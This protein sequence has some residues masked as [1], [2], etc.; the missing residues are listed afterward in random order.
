MAAGGTRR[1]ERKGEP[2]MTNLRAICIL[3]FCHLCA[4][5][6][7]TPP[8]PPLPAA[9]TTGT[10]PSET[11]LGVRAPEVVTT[12]AKTRTEPALR[13]L[14]P[15][16]EQSKVFEAVYQK[17]ETKARRDLKILAGQHFCHSANVN[18]IFETLLKAF[19]SWAGQEIEYARW[20]TLHFAGIVEENSEF[21]RQA[22]LSQ[23]SAATPLSL[24][25]VASAKA[26]SE[27][28]AL[29]AGTKT[30]EAGLLADQ[31]EY[32]AMQRQLSGTGVASLLTILNEAIKSAAEAKKAAESLKKGQLNS[33]WTERLAAFDH[34]REAASDAFAYFNDVAKTFADRKNTILEERANFPARCAQ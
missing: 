8:T 27:T 24:P 29:E 17:A 25:A 19:D 10:F 18:S 12:A 30:A 1:I 2:P 31:E 5:Q 34:E 4:A 16:R 11:P 13:E 26:D 7:V 28:E 14:A 22:S 23:V 9:T 33:D 15:F 6:S 32:N 3:I 20:A 21:V